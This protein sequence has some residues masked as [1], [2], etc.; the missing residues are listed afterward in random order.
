MAENAGSLYD[1]INFT[2]RHK[3]A[4]LEVLTGIDISKDLDYQSHTGSKY[5]GLRMLNNCIKIKA[6]FAKAHFL[7]FVTRQTPDRFEYFKSQREQLAAIIQW[8]PSPGEHYM[9]DAINPRW[10]L[11][12]ANGSEVF[13]DQNCLHAEG[14]NFIAMYDYPGGC[15]EPQEERAVFCTFVVIDNTVTHL[16]QWAKQYDYSGKE[17]YQ[18]NVI[19]YFPALKQLLFWAAQKVKESIPLTS[20]SASPALPPGLTSEL[21]AATQ[22]SEQDMI[23]EL[24]ASFLKPDERWLLHSTVWEILLTG[25]AKI[26]SGIGV[27]PTI[28]P[29]YGTATAALSLAASTSGGSDISISDKPH[30]GEFKQKP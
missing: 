14:K 12:V 8:E 5:D 1:Q 22:T 29:A 27:T 6:C 11:D 18:V 30:V 3:D 19:P 21:V 24:Q 20:V 9:A 17:Y 26:T 23:R 15:G 7:Q 2:R 16:I 4:I 10:K 28:M 25:V 13:Y